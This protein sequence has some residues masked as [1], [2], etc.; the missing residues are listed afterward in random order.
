MPRRP[1]P[2][3]KRA[4][5]LAQRYPAAVVGDALTAWAEAAGA[6][7]FARRLHTA[8]F[9][10]LS[11]RGAKTR[12][13]DVSQLLAALRQQI[14][15]RPS[16]DSTPYDRYLPWLAQALYRRHQEAVKWIRSVSRL[17]PVDPILARRLEAISDVN[18]AKS[19]FANAPMTRDTHDALERA[20]R[21]P[22][23]DPVARVVPK[24]RLIADWA[25]DE[26]VDLGSMNLGT[27][28]ESAEAWFSAKKWAGRTPPGS[29]VFAWPDKWTIRE[30]LTKEDLEYEG[31]AM[32]HC[33]G[34]YDP[35]QI[36]PGRETKWRLFSL[37]DPENRPHAT[38]EW[39]RDQQY[40]L[41]LRGK[42]NAEPLRK[43][44]ERMVAFRLAMFPIYQP[45]KQEVD[46]KDP[47][48]L[49]EHFQ[50]R[51]AVQTPWRGLVMVEI[52]DG[53]PYLGTDVDEDILDQAS[54][55]FDVMGEQEAV[56]Q[57]MY[58][59]YAPHEGVHAWSDFPPRYETYLMEQGFAP[60]YVDD[61]LVQGVS[62]ELTTEKSFQPTK[63]GRKTADNW[64]AG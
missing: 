54:R 16:L 6:D 49:S 23:T 26:K 20:I 12:A 21:L 61:E 9:L 46:A 51:Y 64:I 8:Q 48:L 18:K 47:R 43:Y 39:D 2:V 10:P 3:T 36:G 19:L 40:V 41:Q 42:G 14:E 45:W 27:A 55:L 28:I 29:T 38:L 62:R 1:N 22:Y 4:A 32:G 44:L 15:A 25:R 5:W 35:E 59:G 57:I 63:G 52:W 11:P 53:Y 33:V 56:E 17:R 34:A 13:P 31:A 30:L 50:G 37:R 7:D 58:E 60:L 24:F